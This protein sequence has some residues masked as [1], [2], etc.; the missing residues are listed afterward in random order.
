MSVNGVRNPTPRDLVPGFADMV[1]KAREAKG[2]SQRELSRQAEV[3]AMCVCDLEAEKRS[4][5]LRVAALIAKALGLDVQ[6]SE[7]VTKQKRV[8]AKP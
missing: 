1:R 6:L 3:S 5:S 8:K 7:P 4:P 2:W